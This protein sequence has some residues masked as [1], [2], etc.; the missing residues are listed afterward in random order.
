MDVS[1][2]TM[3][4]FES[5][6]VSNSP[7]RF[8]KQWL[9]IEDMLHEI[10][11][12]ITCFAVSCATSSAIPVPACIT[13][14]NYYL[15]KWKIC[16]LSRDRKMALSITY[17]QNVRSTLQVIPLAWWDNSK[18]CYVFLLL[19]HRRKGMCDLQVCRQLWA[20]LPKFQPKSQPLFPAAESQLI[21]GSISATYFNQGILPHFWN[22]RL[23]II[24]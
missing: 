15:I 2:W 21:R 14:S 18:L 16:M 3:N 9:Q 6:R 4:V 24:A 8:S 1:L 17:K 20:E 19:R 23:Y 12:F 10:R 22:A 11:I 5:K 13:M 7:N